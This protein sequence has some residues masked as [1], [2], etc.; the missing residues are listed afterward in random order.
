MVVFDNSRSMLSPPNAPFDQTCASRDDFWVGA[1]GAA[2]SVPEYPLS[3]WAPTGAPGACEDPAQPPDKTR[4][5]NKLCIGKSVMYDALDAY[6]SLVSIGFGSYYQYLRK[7]EFAIG[8]TKFSRCEYDVIAGPG[9]WARASDH[10]TYGDTGALPLTAYVG[11]AAGAPV[12]FYPLKDY[13]ATTCYP[14]KW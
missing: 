14:T 1:G 3:S 10:L 11:P 13:N 8:P 5:R 4:C 6:Q 2:I 12:E 7:L 9:E